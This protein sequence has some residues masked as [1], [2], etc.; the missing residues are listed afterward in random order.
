MKKYACLMMILAFLSLNACGGGGSSGF[1]GQGEGSGSL[2]SVPKLLLQSANNGSLKANL[3]VYGPDGHLVHEENL[4]INEDTGEVFG[5]AFQLDRGFSYTFVVLFTYTQEPYGELPIAFVAKTATTEDTFLSFTWSAAEV[6]TALSQLS[7]N[8]I[9]AINDLPLAGISFDLDADHYDNFSEIREGSN[10]LSADSIP[11]APALESVTISSKIDE[12]EGVLIFSDTSGVS[13][14]QPA[15]PYRCGYITWEVESLDQDSHRKSLHFRFNLHSHASI[16]DGDNLILPIQVSDV[17][18]IKEIHEI[19][20]PNVEKN[21]IY[22]D[23]LDSPSI[24]ILSPLPGEQVSDFVQVEAIACDEDGVSSLSIANIAGVSD[25]NPDPEGFSGSLDTSTLGDGGQIITLQATDIPNNLNT[26]SVSVEVANNNPIIVIYPQP[27]STLQDGFNLVLGINE[28]LMPNPTNLFVSEVTDTTPER[29]PIF[30]LNLLKFDLN[31]LPE[32]FTSQVFDTSGVPNQEF[33]VMAVAVGENGEQITRSI[34]YLLNNYPRITTFTPYGQNGPYACLVDGNIQLE[35]QVENTGPT[36]GV[37][38][39]GMDVP[40]VGTSIGFD[41]FECAEQI[42]LSAFRESINGNTGVSQILEAQETLELTPLSL[43]LTHASGIVEPDQFEILINP[44]D[45]AFSTDS[46]RWEVVLNNMTSGVMDSIEVTGGVIDNSHLHLV[47]FSSYEIRLNLKNIGN[48][49]ISSS[50]VYSFSTSDNALSLW[51]GFENFLQP[52]Q[53]QSGKENNGILNG[54]NSQGVGCYLGLCAAFDGEELIDGQDILQFGHNASLDPTQGFTIRLYV[55][56]AN[57]GGG[58]GPNI[59]PGVLLH[60]EGQYSLYN[61]GSELF[62]SIWDALD[63]EQTISLPLNTVN[64]DTWNEISVIYN[65]DL[66]GVPSQPTF[67]LQ[68]N[69]LDSGPMILDA[70]AIETNSLMIGGDSGPG[71]ALFEGSLDEV[72]IYD[73]PLSLGEL[74]QLDSIL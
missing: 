49:T 39:A 4:Q 33:Y 40:A 42:Y 2:G 21:L 23:E 59:A 24:A 68:L 18:G 43:D 13:T 66:A 71:G 37:E 64:P 55:N 63:N 56:W 45:P 74:S 53:D 34:K 69:G 46:L 38:I 7:S 61:D 65:A 5:N 8:M 27:G 30:A 32:A 57:A 52:A 15:N 26:A 36:G 73:H 70:V 22:P 28:D 17:L 47:P 12:V 62:F 35:W 58:G 67:S 72:L 41:G 50:Q 48:E 20:V 9:A 14:L 25:S 3:T 6:M 19:S 60:K 10:P 16:N 11:L 31:V 51:L 1:L 54:V 44:S 29:N